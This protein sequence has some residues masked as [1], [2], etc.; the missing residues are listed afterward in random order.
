MEILRYITWPSG[1]I[2]GPVLT[3]FVIDTSC[4]LWQILCDDSK[5]SC[6]VYDR[7][8]MGW[9]LFL[10]WI[11]VKLFSAVFFF[12]ASIKYKNPQADTEKVLKP[13]INNGLQLHSD[14]KDI[15]SVDYVKTNTTSNGVVERTDSITHL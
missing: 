1:T 4:A 5:G 11:S 3:G 8:E 15:R 9:R 7:Y 14:E 10:W 2:P 6:Y 12:I 13:E